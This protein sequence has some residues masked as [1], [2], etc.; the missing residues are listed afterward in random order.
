MRCVNLD[1]Q[2]VRTFPIFASSCFRVFAISLIACHFN[3]ATLNVGCAQRCSVI[4]IF[5]SEAVYYHC[6][7]AGVAQLVE[8]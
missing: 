6:D 4:D 2:A 1:E 3:C 5:G 8:R 7:R